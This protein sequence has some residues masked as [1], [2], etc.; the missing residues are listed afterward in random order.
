MLSKKTTSA[1]VSA[2]VTEPNHWLTD[3]LDVMR[4]EFTTTMEL[5]T[6]EQRSQV[7]ELKAWSPRDELAHLAFW[8]E[9][10]VS[11]LRHLRDGSALI[12]THNYLAMNDEAW[13]ARQDWAWEDIK[14]AL[15]NA[16][17]EL[18]TNITRLSSEELTDSTCLTLEGERK[19]P[20]PLIRNFL[21][22]LVDHPLHHF[23]GLYL[24]LGIDPAL[25]NAML[26]RV[27]NVLR[28]RGVSKWASTSRRKVQLY[29]KQN[30][31]A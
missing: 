3:V 18:E 30:S 22:E 21:Y 20:R 28:R 5:F 2:K 23:V 8:L 12:D 19:S 10:F 29:L 15:L 6:F 25:L 7:G 13:L 27:D 1:S 16:L 24:R 9:T 11:N 26:M 31:S 17:V 14:A 4:A